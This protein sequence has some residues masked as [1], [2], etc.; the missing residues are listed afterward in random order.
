MNASD[1]AIDTNTLNQRLKG[2]KINAEYI[3]SIGF[4]GQSDPE[5]VQQ[6]A[7]DVRSGASGRRL[8]E[9]G[10]HLGESVYSG[11]EPDELL[12]Y[13]QKYLDDLSD[14]GVQRSSSF[15]QGFRD[16]V[17]VL[18]DPS[19][20]VESKRIP[21]SFKS[22]DK[23]LDGGLQLGQLDVSAGRTGMGKTSWACN[24]MT[25]IA[26]QGHSCLMISIEM[27]E[28]QIIRKILS[29]CLKIHESKFVQ[30][31]MS[32]EDWDV[33][34]ERNEEMS[35]LPIRID[36]RSRSLFEIIASI[37]NHVRRYDTKFVVV[38]YIQRVKVPTRDARYLE[39]GEVCEDLADLAKRLQINIMVL[40]QINR[41]VEHRTSKRP[42]MS[43]LSE[44]GKIEETAS[45]IFMLY[46]DDAYDHD[47][48]E[49]G[50]A[51]VH[52]VKNRFGQVGT[53]KLAFAKEYTLFADIY[54]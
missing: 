21:T 47:S 29:G 20:A 5:I 23:F 45:R 28:P 6:Y 42:V 46:R 3:E 11:K 16:L 7:Q 18:A 27:P 50:F 4:Y 32:S 14:R 13:A 48:N 36:D 43:D 53:A 19:L 49:K 8:V 51:E 26:K 30:H 39:V 17:E 2:S 1:I 22:I 10:T 40:S 38:D 35:S 44:S 24:L 31:N 25:N 34:L 54:Q 12:E 33:L 15:H 52:L 37:R 9:L 41:Q